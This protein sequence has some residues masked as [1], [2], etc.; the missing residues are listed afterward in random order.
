[1]QQQDCGRSKLKEADRIMQ[2]LVDN[3]NAR[4][5]LPSLKLGDVPKG[6]NKFVR[7]KPERTVPHTFYDGGGKPWQ[8]DLPVQ[9][10]GKIA[11]NQ[12][13]LL[14]SGVDQKASLKTETKWGN[15]QPPRR[16]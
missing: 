12:H 4:V 3:H 11:E 7:P 15:R 5:E 14:A 8:V 2:G 1:M 9:R 16:A 13:A 10:D 6:A